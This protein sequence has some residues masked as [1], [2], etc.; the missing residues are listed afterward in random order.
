[1][2]NCR[3]KQEDTHLV[4]EHFLNVITQGDTNNYDWEVKYS[5]LYIVCFYK[6]KFKFAD[7]RRGFCYFLFIPEWSELV[8]LFT[9]VGRSG[10]V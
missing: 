7:F 1:M 3:G 2:T 4:G 5:I 6:G 9:D 10:H 8:L